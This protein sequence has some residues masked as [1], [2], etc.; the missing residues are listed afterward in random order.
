MN[1]LTK[2]LRQL[3]RVAFW[4]C[5][6]LISFSGALGARFFS[7]SFP[8]KD[9]VSI[10]LAGGV[11][12]FIGLGVLSLGT[13]AWLQGDGA[14]DDADPGQAD[15]PVVEPPAKAESDRP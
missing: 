6:A 7:E 5:G 2:R 3:P 4:I 10:W 11:I 1:A 14:A 8:L 15:A 9:R 13:R 12:V